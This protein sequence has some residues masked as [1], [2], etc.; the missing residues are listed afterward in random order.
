MLPIKKGCEP[1]M[2][3]YGGVASQLSTLKVVIVFEVIV[4]TTCFESSLQRLILKT[5]P[6][7]RRIERHRF[8][9][10]LACHMA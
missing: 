9:L 1:V 5:T 3:I 10:G 2:C 7:V 8:L 4:R 6:L